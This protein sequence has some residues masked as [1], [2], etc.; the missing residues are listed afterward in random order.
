MHTLYNIETH[1]IRQQLYLHRKRPRE[2]WD[3]ST[4]EIP[5]QPLP[6]QQKIHWDP[7]SGRFNCSNTRQSPGVVFTTLTKLL[8]PYLVRNCDPAERRLVPPSCHQPTGCLL[9]KENMG[10]QSGAESRMLPRRSPKPTTYVSTF[11]SALMAPALLELGQFDRKK[12]LSFNPH[13]WC[14]D[15]CYSVETRA[16]WATYYPSTHPF[17]A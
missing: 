12:R 13:F 6:K 10:D 5:L 4:W 17:G 16:L 2:D 3:P 11:G 9:F 1:I 8:R 15:D 14:I 7:W